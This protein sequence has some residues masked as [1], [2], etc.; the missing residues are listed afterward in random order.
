ME[1]NLKTEKRKL[2]ELRA[3]EYNPRKTLTPEDS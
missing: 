2:T 1:Q 3:A